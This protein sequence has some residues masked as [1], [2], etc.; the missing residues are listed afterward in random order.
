MP[1]INIEQK[2]TYN[3]NSYA[4]LGSTTENFAP[5]ENIQIQFL[6]YPEI[7]T[8][9]NDRIGRKIRTDYITY[10]TYYLMNN[11]YSYDRSIG[12]FYDDY[13]KAATLAE[14]QDDVN[15]PEGYLAVDYLNSVQRPLDVT[16]REM[17]VE[18]DRDFF[19]FDRLNSG[20][21]DRNQFNNEIQFK[22]HDW[23]EKLVIQ[24][25]L[26]YYP[27]NKNQVRRESTKYTG[28][29]NIIKEKIWHF[30]HLNPTHHEFDT[31]K[32]VRNMNF[33][34]KPANLTDEQARN[35]LTAP[36]DKVLLRL[37]IGPYNYF[38]DYGNMGFS[39][40]MNSLDD[41][42]GSTSVAVIK[43]SM[44]LSYTDV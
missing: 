39:I 23:Y 14:Q 28:N 36:S 8:D 30:S 16:I 34:P 6:T 11:N 22:L 7:G 43:T 35:Y 33:E 12:R 3:S 44:K 5:V 31:I 13:I 24:T 27:S 42:E 20:A 1:K 37:W 38:I 21:I 4:L 2:H 32:Y 19:P 17:F 25:G 9:E 41:V 26:D 18:F 29:F 10:E 15:V 40:Y